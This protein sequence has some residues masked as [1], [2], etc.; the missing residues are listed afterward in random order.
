MVC[1]AA[2]I[3]PEHFP[4]AVV[5]SRSENT[6]AK[7]KDGLVAAVERLERSLILPALEEAGGV[8]SKA[9]RALGITERMISYKMQ[10]LGISRPKK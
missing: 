4:P 8:K 2:E 6:R 10:N 3:L 1:D 5:Q 9:A 7:V